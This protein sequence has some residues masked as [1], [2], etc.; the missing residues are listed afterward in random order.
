MGATP[1]RQVLLR[2]GAHRVYVIGED[3]LACGG[4]V[5]MGFQ[6]YCYRRMSHF[7]EV[8]THSRTH[9]QEPNVLSQA[10]PGL[11]VSNPRPGSH[12][13]C[14]AHSRVCVVL[15]LGHILQEVGT[16]ARQLLYYFDQVFTIL[17]FNQKKIFFNLTPDVTG[18]LGPNSTVTYFRARHL[19]RYFPV[20]PRRGTLRQG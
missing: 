16:T 8:L 6:L 14:V 19:L 20:E 10:S 17:G 11:S 15:S 3:H 5:R 13:A 2:N 12:L 18:T 1:T 7:S 4:F 9:A